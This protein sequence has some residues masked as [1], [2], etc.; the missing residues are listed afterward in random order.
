MTARLVACVTMMKDEDFYLPVWFRYYAGQFGARNLY[1]LDHGSARPVADM[2]PDEL[3]PEQINVLRIPTPEECTPGKVVPQ[4]DA[5]RFSLINPFLRSLLTYYD[6]VIFNDTDEIF[7][8]DPARHESLRDYIATAAPRRGVQ[9]GLGMDLFHD[10]AGE[11]PFDPLRPI[12]QQRRHFQWQ[13]LYSKPH[14]LSRAAQILPHMSSHVFTLDPDLYLI[15]MKYI[16]RDKIL[17]RQMARRETAARLGKTKQLTWR[18]PDEAAVQHLERLNG[19][20]D[21]PPAWSAGRALMRD[22][23]GRDAAF[24]VGEEPGLTIR[25]EKGKTSGYRLV[26]FLP[27]GADRKARR[28]RCTLADSFAATGH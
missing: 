4:F 27:E 21:A 28:V 2:L 8:P 17:G 26:D 12:F 6:V 18:K 1:I 16:D 25:G 11:A 7:M 10:A 3:R 5:Q 23:V 9:A 24:P 13:M 22:L 20:P 19:L 15:H 14:I